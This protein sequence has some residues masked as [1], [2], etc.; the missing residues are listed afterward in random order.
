M[1]TCD[2]LVCMNRVNYHNVKVSKVIVCTYDS[3]YL[4]TN[5]HIPSVGM[6]RLMKLYN[7]I[8]DNT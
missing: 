2:V 8:S 1:I 5:I 6:V 7:T 3:L 4:H